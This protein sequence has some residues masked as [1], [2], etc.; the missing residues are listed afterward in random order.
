MTVAQESLAS[1]P[2]SVYEFLPQGLQDNVGSSRQTDAAIH[3]TAASTLPDDA[4]ETQKRALLR[5]LEHHCREMKLLIAVE[6][7][8]SYIWF[9]ADGDQIAGVLNNAGSAL[10]GLG[11]LKLQGISRLHPARHP[12]SDD[13]PVG[14]RTTVFRS[15][16]LN[17]SST[18]LRSKAGTPISAPPAPSIFEQSLHAS[19]YANAKA[20][21]AKRSLSATAAPAATVSTPSDHHAPALDRFEDPARVHAHFISAVMG[22]LSYRL[23]SL[24]NYIPLNFRTFIN[25]LPSGIEH[26]TRAEEKAV[27]LTTLDIRLTTS[28]SL[29]VV[30]E[31]S[32]EDG[33]V[34]VPASTAPS[35]VS[36]IHAGT[37]LWLAPGGRIARYIGTHLPAQ[38]DTA[39][40]RSRSPSPVDD[41][42]MG[43]INSSAEPTVKRW[44]AD[45]VT[46]LSQKGICLD[47]PAA[48]QRWIWVEILVLDRRE[49]RTGTNKEKHPEMAAR[50]IVPIL[51]PQA[52]CVRR[53]RA[54]S[55]SLD[56][57][58]PGRLVQT[59]PGSGRPLVDPLAFAQSW[60]GQKEQRDRRTKAKDEARLVEQTTEKAEARTSPGVDQARADDS[61][62]PAPSVIGPENADGLDGASGMHQTPPDGL[63]GLAGRGPGLVAPPEP[64][65]AHPPAANLPGEQSGADAVAGS[66]SRSVAHEQSSRWEGPDGK[67]DASHGRKASA[68]TVFELD[69]GNFRTGDGGPT[70]GH[71]DE[72]MFNEIG[73]TEED[74]SFFDDPASGTA[75]NVGLTEAQT[76]VGAARTEKDAIQGSAD[77]AGPG[78]DQGAKSDRQDDAHIDP[79]GSRSPGP[80]RSIE[81][82]A[83]AGEEAGETEGRPGSM[84]DAGSEPEEMDIVS[85]EASATASNDRPHMRP[86]VQVVSPPLDPDVVMKKLLPNELPSQLGTASGS[87][88]RE[89]PSREQAGDEPSG[90]E[91]V[92]FNPTLEVATNKYD[93][94]GRF[95]FPPSDKTVGRLGET[96]RNAKENVLPRITASNTSSGFFPHRKDRGVLFLPNAP[97]ANNSSQPPQILASYSDHPD[98]SNKAS[99][100]SARRPDLAHSTHQKRKRNS[101]DD[102]ASVECSLQQLALKPAEP[103][104]LI[105]LSLDSMDGNPMDWSMAGLFPRIPSG[106]GVALGLRNGEYV[107]S[108]QQIPDQVRLQKVLQRVKGKAHDEDETSL[109]LTVTSRARHAFEDVLLDIFPRASQCDLS[110]YRVIEDTHFAGSGHPYA[111]L[112]RQ[113][114]QL[115]RTSST[116]KPE[117][118]SGASRDAPMCLLPPPH[119][120]VRRGEISI[121]VLPPAL[122][123]W[124]TLSFGPCGGPKNVVS[125]CVFAP[126]EN[127]AAALDQFLESVASAYESYRFGRHTRGNLFAYY[128]GL[129]PVASDEEDPPG[130]SLQG[131]MARFRKAC[132]Q[133]GK[134][135]VQLG[136]M[137]LTGHT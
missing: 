53:Y 130:T 44:K 61:S 64:A 11:P 101:N 81:T 123:F 105:P 78:G 71:L 41:T 15:S 133:L 2:Y 36:G 48:E 112:S 76:K 136:R 69:A 122:E 82:L 9:F 40:A 137:E 60:Y 38:G 46:W 88:A 19:R 37:E 92:R 102:S 18:M 108:A 43:S 75:G 66:R 125:F 14:L 55:N 5:R 56:G 117:I 29:L 39:P 116:P 93:Q 67:G 51:W 30:P 1:I 20:I 110:S 111:H 59:I 49:K 32:R 132:C 104:T 115:R 8:S 96:R 83:K 34:S 22:L 94:Q 74:F 103:S 127:T 10:A 17:Q 70:F 68:A 7:D 98:V 16:K 119:V 113:H 33:L 135:C 109:S 89:T 131:V 31:T 63:R 95:S 12:E 52:L 54:Q 77:I 21:L 85:D 24:H 47:A 3:T 13:G 25:P 107:Q 23:S 50:A 120:Q 26:A 80:E 86:K 134:H 28:G 6:P 62:G 73:V 121:Q 90:F 45:V 97:S 84:S 72:D 42:R 91:P 124:E 79:D 129:V 126:L 106:G 128:K 57:K 87:E 4:I 114:P 100:D 65:P 35:D 118:A 27:W 58:L 99:N